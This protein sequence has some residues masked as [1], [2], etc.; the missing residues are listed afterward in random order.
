MGSRGSGSCGNG[1]IFLSCGIGSIC[2]SRMTSG[3]PGWTRSGGSSGWTSTAITG[4]P[5]HSRSDQVILPEP[6]LLAPNV[7]HTRQAEA[8]AVLPR[9]KPWLGNRVWLSR[10]GSSE[11]IR[12]V[13]TGG[14]GRGTAD[15]TRLDDPSPRG[16]AGRR[17]GGHLR[18]GR[19]RRR[20]HQ[21]GFPRRPV[22]GIAACAPDPR[23][24]SGDRPHST[25][26]LWPGRWACINI[27]SCRT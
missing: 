25:T 19:G 5:R 22:V 21:L 26:M 15:G 13:R 23:Q 12:P 2:R 4:L 27:M 16:S 10:R 11:T 24:P 20:L 7:L 14:R 9:A 17:P 6:G 1:R 3:R 18:H 8:L